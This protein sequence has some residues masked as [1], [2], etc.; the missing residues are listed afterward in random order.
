MKPADPQ[1]LLLVDPVSGQLVDRF[2]FSLTHL[3]AYALHWLT[4]WEIP[5]LYENVCVLCARLFPTQFSLKGFPQIPDANRVNRSLL[6]MR[7]K[8]RGFATSDP[9]RG[10]FLTGKGQEAANRVIAAFG[11]PTLGGRQVEPAFTSTGFQTGKGKDRTRNPAR[12]IAECRQKLLF[13]RFKEGRFEDTDTV[14]F[15]GLVSLYDHSPTSEIK[16]KLRQLHADA[17]AVGDDEFLSFLDQVGERFAPY[18]NR[19]QP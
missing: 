9:R 2:Q 15:L 10:V 19:D 5:T 4:V 7:P 1:D 6:Q 13:R 14:H 18:L 11:P 17:L 16:K 3:T 12:I 8:Y